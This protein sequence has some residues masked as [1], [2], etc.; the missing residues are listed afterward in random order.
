MRRRTDLVLVFI[1]ALVLRLGIVLAAVDLPIG[2]DDMFQYDM[3]G[4]SIASGNGYRWYAQEDLARIQEFID[5]EPPANY[6]PQGI[7]TSFRAPLYPA[8]LAL[9]YALVGIGPR[10]FL[11]ARLVQAVLGAGVAPLAALLGDRMGFSR[12]AGL[13]GGV[14]VALYPLLGIY[15]LALATEVLFIPLLA[16]SLWAVLRA[17]DEGRARGFAL[18]GVL[19]GLTA[20]TRSVISLF[21]PLVFLWIWLFDDKPRQGLRNAVLVLG[22][23]LLVI[24]PWAVRN[25]LLHGQIQFIESSLGYNLYMGYHPESTGT[26][27]WRVSS[28]LI[29]ILDDAER[30]QLGTE[31]FRSF[32]RQDPARV[33]YLMFRKL[34]Y[35]WGLD[36]R[37]FIYFYVNNFLGRWP[38]ALI[39]GALLLLCG[40]FVLLAPLALAGL[41]LTRPR[42]ATILVIALVVYFVGIH[43]LIMADAR[44]HVPLIPILAPV[45][46]HA[47]VDLPWR[48]ARRW[49]KVLAVVLVLALLTNW[50]WELARDWELLSRLLGPD[51][52][53]LWLPY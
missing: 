48:Q 10:R 4:R 51:G 24:L 30:N 23:F 34:G 12:R 27:T 29:P 33:P 28:D 44:F 45:A 25:T 11:A 53:R 14:I 6:D 38:P 41:A 32:V 20:L 49:Q 40:P 46:A 50:S 31:A 35:F 42:R 21:V 36:K 2:L 37:A 47:I 39:V 43:M 15:T 1:L 52:H 5:M 3:L 26:F 18:A 9:I 17:A 19:L 7:L 16:L 8:F 13:V 22:C